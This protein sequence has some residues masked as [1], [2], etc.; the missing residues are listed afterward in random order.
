MTLS[1]HV[2]HQVEEASGH[3]RKYVQAKRPQRA[4]GMIYEGNEGGRRAD[5]VEVALRVHAVSESETSL[6]CCLKERGY[7]EMKNTV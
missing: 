2:S 4:V 6:H 3:S 7:E 5:D 1:K